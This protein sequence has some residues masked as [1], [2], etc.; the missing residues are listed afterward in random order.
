MRFRN[1]WIV[2]IVW[3]RFGV[4]RAFRTG[5]GTDQL[6]QEFR[7][8]RLGIS[9][10]AAKPIISGSLSAWALFSTKQRKIDQRFS[11]A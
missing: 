7:P 8:D 9:F 2:P 1:L 10:S 5:P 11:D 4:R 3:C 6:A